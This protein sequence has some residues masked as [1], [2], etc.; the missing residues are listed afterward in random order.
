[1]TGMLWHTVTID[2]DGLFA[3]SLAGGLGISASAI[4]ALA[5][6][7]GL[8]PLYLLRVLGAGDVKLATALGAWVGWQA[9]LPWALL[10]M[11][12]GGVLALAWMINT[13]RRSRVLFN[14]YSMTMHSFVEGPRAA[15]AGFD[16]QAAAADRL[17]YAWAILAG[18]AVFAVA[19]YQGGW[20]LL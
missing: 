10:V 11:I 7:A 18:T 20:G 14:L 8:F 9:L 12:S 1:A 17:P 15:I 3:S 5:A 6:F 2:G 4:G 19:H 13:R 16:P